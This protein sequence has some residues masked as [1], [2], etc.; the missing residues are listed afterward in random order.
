[1]AG[2][3]PD[4]SGNKAIPL[5]KDGVGGTTLEPP[6]PPCMGPNSIDYFVHRDQQNSEEF[7][8]I[9]EII[10]EITPNAPD[11]GSTVGY[12]VR[13]KGQSHLHCRIAKQKE[14]ENNNLAVL[15]SYQKTKTG[16]Q[17]QTYEG[18]EYTLLTFVG[19]SFTLDFCQIQDI[20]AIR[21]TDCS[22]SR[23]DDEEYLVLWKGLTPEDAS[24]ESRSFLMQSVSRSEQTSLESMICDRKMKTQIPF[25]AIV[26]Q[27]QTSASDTDDSQGDRKP[28]AS[29]TKNSVLLVN[30][31]ER[32][33]ILPRIAD[34]IRDELRKIRPPGQSTCPAWI[35]CPSTNT[36][37]WKEV[38][39]LRKLQTVVHSKPGL[40]TPEYAEPIARLLKRDAETPTDAKELV[41]V[42]IM[43]FD[44][45]FHHFGLLAGLD[46]A[47]VIVDELR[48]FSCEDNMFRQIDKDGPGKLLQG[49]KC[50]GWIVTSNA[51][52]EGGKGLLGLLELAGFRMRPE[53]KAWLEGQFQ[54]ADVCAAVV[55]QH[56]YWYCPGVCVVL[57]DV[58][59][60]G[61]LE[62]SLGE[63]VDDYML[64]NFG[65]EMGDDAARF[66]R[67]R[68][69][70]MEEFLTRC[71]EFD[72]KEGPSR[73]E[74][75]VGKHRDAF[76]DLPLIGGNFK[77]DEEKE[78][79]KRFLSSLCE[80]GLESVRDFAKE[81]GLAQ[82]AAELG[83]PEF[84]AKF[85][86]ES[87]RETF[88]ETEAKTS[89]G[90][91]MF[92]NALLSFLIEYLVAG[93]PNAIG[94]RAN[95][96]VQFVEQRIL[97]QGL[98]T[99]KEFQPSQPYRLI[100]GL[101]WRC[102]HLRVFLNRFRRSH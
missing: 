99:C 93:D 52:R 8:Q 6:L 23:T 89:R 22:S 30:D 68:L 47:L 92:R 83:L 90:I 78:A 27:P 24:W 98:A 31:E 34:N 3:S 28:S 54:N 64:H 74:Q 12:F 5:G 33:R 59:G 2:T 95:E 96:I 67:E 60:S 53:G 26:A 18:S 72:E 86:L 13:F 32:P 63:R 40:D 58:N 41:D 82:F 65:K 36:L 75:F 37:E 15:E 100:S 45:L 43:S 79:N 102:E 66:V 10:G 19:Q 21:R 69:G 71:S 38:L 7:A 48:G 77:S 51:L 25:A 55:V 62:I 97:G 61:S 4:P 16:T 50:P 44:W 42:V 73:Y 88:H 49:L 101:R 91:E 84:A 81:L 11:S 70:A 29:E 9:Q 20:L 87:G 46:S 1:M 17:T 57:K 14:I 56:I 94:K 35:F 80:P 85:A 39:S 76:R